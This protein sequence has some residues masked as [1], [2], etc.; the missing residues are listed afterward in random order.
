MVALLAGVLVR[1]DIGRLL[2]SGV[3]HKDAL[4]ETESTE[5]NVG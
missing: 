1:R 4:G 5:C 3:K 2:V